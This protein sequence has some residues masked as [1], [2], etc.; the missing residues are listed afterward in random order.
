MIPHSALDQK[1]INPNEA[2][3]IECNAALRRNPN[4]VNAHR[5]KGRALINLGC[6]ADALVSLK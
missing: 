6:Y 1:S 2:I 5:V 3:L 4:D